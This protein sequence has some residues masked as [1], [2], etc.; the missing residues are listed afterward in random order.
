LKIVHMADS[1]LGFSN[2]SRVDKYGRNLVE[3]M[4]Y[5]GFNQAVDRII[6]LKPDAVVHAGDVFHHVRPRIRPLYAFKQ[7]LEKLQDAGIPVVVISG[8]HD[9]P[10]SYSAISPFY[11]YEG[12]KGVNIAHRYKYERFDLGDNKVHCIPFCLDPGDYLKEFGKIDRSGNDVLVMHGLVEALSNKKMR[13]VGEHELKDSLLK[14]D[15]D[16]IA[17]GHYHG[18]A[19]ISE[20]AWYS[21]SIEYFNFGE[22]ADK[23]GILFV[24]LEKREAKPIEVRPRYMIDLPPIDCSGM[25]SSELA[26]ELFDLCD[27][28]EIRDRIIRVNLKNVQR[29][30]YRNL[31]HVRLNKLSSTAL[32]FKIKVEYEDEKEQ[33]DAPVDSIRLHEEFVKFL[34]DEAIRGG[35]SRGIKDDVTAYGSDLLKKAVA[36]HITE[37]LNAPE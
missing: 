32:H 25:S 12:M 20:N 28:E 29:S 35:I 13:T 23:K 10:K 3:E 34:E 33:V 26:E 18:Q 5:D 15:F 31:N 11:I 21:G 2:Y 17:L 22:A 8:N 19:R 14:S 9:A 4:I 27:P 30:A 24:D 7:G 16:Y 37:A 1:H 36:A 6:E